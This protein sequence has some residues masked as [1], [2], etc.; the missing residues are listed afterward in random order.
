MHIHKK[1]IYNLNLLEK[2]NGG[3]HQVECI[4]IVS[5]MIFMKDGDAK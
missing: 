2:K 5:S 1:R 4:K 3:T